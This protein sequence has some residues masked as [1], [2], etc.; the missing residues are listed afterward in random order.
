MSEIP[1]Y[2]DT[3]VP[4]YFREN[5]W[6]NSQNSILFL[7][8]AFSKCSLDKRSIVHD[9]KEIILQPFEFITGRSKSAAECLLSE[10]AFKHQL[11]IMQKAGL[12]K[13]TPNSTPNRFT[14]YIW[15]TE[16]F[17]KHNTQLNTQLTP[18]SH[19]TERPQSR[20]K[21][22]RSK[23]DHHPYPSSSKA[24]K[25]DDG[26]GLDDSLSK[27]EEEK[28]E[29][30][31]GRGAEQGIF[32]TQQDLDT[33]IEI[34]DGSIEDVKI[35]ME[36]IL[37]HVGRKTIISSWP[38][39]MRKWDVPKYFAP[40][41]KENEEMGKRYEQMYEEFTNGWRCRKYHDKKK[42]QKGILFEPS[43]PYLEAFFVAFSDGEF[44]EKA[45][46]FLR[47]KKMQKARL[48]IS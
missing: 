6:Y 10:D 44:K 35:A 28:I 16:R 46:G 38:N 25:R 41:I 22:L 3:P 37:N 9:S 29:V 19:P 23:E 2:F 8:W 11:K 43:S 30:Y 20:I 17:L 42:D 31:K 36:Y 27:K 5:G 39:A 48:P 7:T 40:K 14:C 15:L 47:D 13:K 4:K 34:K 45:S 33:C 21:N 32:L 18:N 26:D 1:Y 24:S 12:L